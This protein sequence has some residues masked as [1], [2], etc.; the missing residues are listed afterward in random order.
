MRTRK[1][2]IG[3][4]G[5]TR[6]QMKRGGMIDILMGEVEDELN[7]N[8]GA[9][10]SR[11]K[12]VTKVE[13]M[14]DML[15]F[16]PSVTE[17]VAAEYYVPATAEKALELL[18]AQGVQMR[19]VTQPIKGVQQF[20]IA[21]NTQRP[22][23]TNSIDTGAHGLRTLTGAWEPAADVTVPAGSWAIAMNQPLARLAFYLLAPTSDD[24]LTAWNFMDELLGEGVKTY[25][26]MRRK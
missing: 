25:P 6:S 8:N 5:A 11:R 1:S 2:I 3:T 17:D 14:I 4:L 7:P 19:R 22:A 16:E 15:W 13:P 24:G 18:R 20:T 21:T 26:V 10:M 9:R 23:N 12:D